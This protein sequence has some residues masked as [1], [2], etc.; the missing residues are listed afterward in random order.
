MWN[1]GFL[2]SDAL[3]F[4]SIG[5]VILWVLQYFIWVTNDKLEVKTPYL[6]TPAGILSGLNH[7]F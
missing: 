5:L 1:T 7:G 6:Q 2:W 3:Y 4:S